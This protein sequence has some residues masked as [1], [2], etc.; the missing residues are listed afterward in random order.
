MK[1][2]PRDTLDFNLGHSYSASFNLSQPFLVRRRTLLYP[3]SM[4]FRTLSLLFIS[5]HGSCVF[6]FLGWRVILF[7]P[8]LINARCSP[9]PLALTPSGVT[10]PTFV[11]RDWMGGNVTLHCHPG[12]GGILRPAESGNED[13][14]GKYLGCSAS[15]L[16]HS[17]STSSLDASSPPLDLD[18]PSLSHFALS[19]ASSSS[20]HFSCSTSH[21]GMIDDH[22]ALLLDSLLTS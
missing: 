6:C 18:L 16:S 21:F 15:L 4:F 1:V 7:P 20:S 11:Q 2:F 10:S 8:P 13:E 9:S 5:P 14:V 3:P 12:E 19:S 22:D 17:L